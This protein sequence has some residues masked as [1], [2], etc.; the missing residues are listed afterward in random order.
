MLKHIRKVAEWGIRHDTPAD[1]AQHYRLTNVLLLFMFFASIFETIFLFAT[2]A[3]DAAIINSTAPFT[4]ASGLF[5][6]WTGRTKLARF[7]IVT[8]C[9]GASYAFVSTLGPEA[10]F[11]VILLFASAFA[12]AI[13]SAEEKALMAYG[14]IGPL[15]IFVL[16]EVNGY[17]PIFGME[18]KALDPS[19]AVA[20]RIVS[21]VIVWSL[22]LLH[23]GYFV[24]DRRR[25]QEQL[26]SS[27]KMVALG[28]MAAGIAHEVNNPLQVIVS[29]A[30]RLRV[31]A[32]QAGEA[33]PKVTAAADQIQQ[34]AMRIASINQGLLALSRDAAAD[35]LL[36]VR[37][38]AVVKLALDFC[39]AHLESN[40]VQL[41]VH[42]VPTEWTVMGRETQLSEVI[43]N[44][45]NNAYDAVQECEEKW[46]E[47]DV[48]ASK[49]SIQI[50]VS[51]SGPGVNAK[52]RSKIFD[53]FF[54]TKPAGKGTG[55]GLSISQSIMAVHSGQI[56]YEPKGPGARF[57]VRLPRGA[58][59]VDEQLSHSV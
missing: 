34:V 39:R 23:F 8:I 3:T 51:D 42:P 17:Q 33:S 10:N 18:R 14:I 15:V 28:R 5:L 27:A 16:L 31:A 38:H 50:A 43:L 57:V 45:L 29:H 11:Q 56:T 26:V 35:P 9:Y 6:M 40:Q 58:D 21:H 25:A 59:A 41:R 30:E 44:I 22:M 49:S 47:L 24:R 37:V 54:T 2:G 32:R 7:L 53:P 46:I 12:I 19:A 36:E 52:L 48:E 13:F 55:L 20:I 4:F 1:Q